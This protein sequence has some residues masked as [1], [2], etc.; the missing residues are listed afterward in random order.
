M[1]V[2]DHDAE[3]PPAHVPADGPV[4]WPEVLAESRN[5]AGALIMDL[6]VPKDLAYFSGHFP[7]T[8]IVPGVVQIH[9]AARFAGTRLG[10]S[11]PF[12]HMEVIKFRDLLLPGQRLTL[13]LS[14]QADGARLHFSFRAGDREFSS[15][16]LYFREV[17]V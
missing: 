8:P 4:L 16:R 10:V 9:W 14:Y 15:G 5:E 1:T 11:L 3:G 2:A 17:D 12:R 6:R 7:G 13:Y